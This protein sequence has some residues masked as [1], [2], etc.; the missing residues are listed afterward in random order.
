MKPSQIEFVQPLAWKILWF[1]AALLLLA[2]L[3]NTG[4]KAWQLRQ[5][6]AALAQKIADLR[7]AQ[8][9]QRLVQ[10]QAAQPPQDSPRAGSEA[11]ANRAL[12][13]DWN[14]LYDSIET[15]TLSKIRL[16]QLSMDAVTGQAM[17]EFE[18]DGLMQAGDVTNALSSASGVTWQL[19]RLEN[20]VQAT[21]GGSAKPKG[22]WRAI[23][24]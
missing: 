10:E 7:S 6:E 24:D 21:Y 23:L 22:I 2:L 9:Q 3:T 15:P 1:T 19:E 20:G 12:Q 13:R 4:V 18:L 8:L 11:A 5:Q 16:I 14:R 17:L